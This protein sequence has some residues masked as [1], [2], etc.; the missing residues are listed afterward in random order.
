MKF[1]S[2]QGLTSSLH[3]WRPC[4]Q[5][6]H[7]IKSLVLKGKALITALV[8][9]KDELENEMPVLIKYA[10]EGIDVLRLVAKSCPTLSDP[11][12]CSLPDSSVHGDSPGKNTGVGCHSLLQG[13]F[14]T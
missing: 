11:M 4:F 7:Q 3:G 14:P 8:F 1:Y 9:T 2:R 5:H 12:D 6:Y 10:P 13:I